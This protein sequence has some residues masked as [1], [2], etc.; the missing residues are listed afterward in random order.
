MNE[1]KEKTYLILAMKVFLYNVQ[2]RE[3]RS[4]IDKKA[5]AA[6]F[7]SSPLS[8]SREIKFLFSRILL[9]LVGSVWRRQTRQTDSGGHYFLFAY[10]IYVYA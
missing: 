5:R 10:L 8:L 9:C 7:K 6:S 3:I 4:S 2:I 1:F